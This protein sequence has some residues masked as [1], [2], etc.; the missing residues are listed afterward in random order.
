MS[1]QVR[2]PR[3]VRF[4]IVPM[5]PCSTVFNLVEQKQALLKLQ[6]L[7][8]NTPTSIYK[9]KSSHQYET[10]WFF[11]LSHFSCVLLD[12]MFSGK[13]FNFR[14]I[15][16][17][18]MRQQRAGWKEGLSMPHCGRYSGPVIMQLSH[19]HKKTGLQTNEV[20]ISFRLK[21]IYRYPRKKY[22]E[23]KTVR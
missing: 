4:F 5:V 11:Q 2:H 17:S 10:N 3:I 14:E 1:G 12:K 16:S 7:W 19:S 23:Y 20:E 13:S 18:K 9:Y 21:K 15:M 22:C 8:L 6:I